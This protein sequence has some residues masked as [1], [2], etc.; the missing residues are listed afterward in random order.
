MLLEIIFTTAVQSIILMG[1]L[2]WLVITKL[3]DNIKY[4]EQYLLNDGENSGKPPQDDPW[5]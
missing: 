5:P 3:P 4:I 1:L 2:G